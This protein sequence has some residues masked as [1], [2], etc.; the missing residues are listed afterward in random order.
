[1]RP[2]F[3][4]EAAKWLGRIACAELFHH[5]IK[6]KPLDFDFMTIRAVFGCF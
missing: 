3:L 2:G 6:F 1:M 5:K 4:F